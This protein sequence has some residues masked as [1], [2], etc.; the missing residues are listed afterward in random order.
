MPLPRPTVRATLR[1]ALLGGVVGILAGVSSAAF[2]EALAWAT[3]T[4]IDHGHLIYLLP[5][6]GLGLG[7]V[8]HYLGGRSAGGTDLIVDEIHTPSA[9]VPR[10]MAPLVF[11]GTV[12][13][14]LFGGSAGREGTALQMAGSLTDALGRRLRV[15]ESDRRLLLMAAIAGG[16]GAVFGVP[17]A[18]LVFGLEVQAVGWRTRVQAFL[19]ALAASVVGNLVVEALDVVHTPTPTLASVDLSA[20][21]LGKVVIAGFAFGVTARVFVAATHLVKAAA[22][23]L[24]WTPARP[25]IGGFAVLALS[26]LADTRDYLGLSLPLLGQAFAGGVGIVTA[27]FAWKLVF[28]AVT[29]GTGFPGGEVT[30]LFVIGTTLGVTLAHQLDLPVP[31]LAAIGFVAVF[32]GATKTPLACTVMGLELFGTAPALLLAIACAV[33]VVVAGERGVYAS[34]RPGGVFTL[35]R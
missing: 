30:P 32:A 6:V 20:A 23:R 14:H 5:A 4:R 12:V 27:A 2:L 9:W 19:P 28:T 35:R 13:T 34:Q 10:R 26:A 24:D 18:G 8:Y 31:L 1:L 15:T 7:L 33:S 16:F 3:R 17:A 29:L 21:L 22:Q 11:A 25:V